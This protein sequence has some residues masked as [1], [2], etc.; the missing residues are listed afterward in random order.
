MIRI[1]SFPIFIFLATLSL[2]SFHAHAQYC[3][4][5]G[6]TYNYEWIKEVKMNSM[7][8]LSG[9]NGYRLFSTPVFQINTGSNQLNL[10]PGFSSNVY[11]EKWSVFI[12]FNQDG[13]FGTGETV[14]NGTSTTALAGTVTVPTTAKSG[15]TRMRVSMAY[16]MAPMPCSNFTYGEVEDY[17]VNI[18]N[19]T[20]PPSTTVITTTLGGFDKTY[21]KDLVIIAKF[22]KGGVLYNSSQ[23]FSTSLGFSRQISL[24]VDKGTQIE[25]SAKVYLATT[26]EEYIPAS[27]SSIVG[28]KCM[29]SAGSV[30]QSVI[31]KLKEHAPPPI[32]PAFDQ[33]I[34]FNNLFGGVSYQPGPSTVIDGV[35]VTTTAN[36]FYNFSGF[37]FT[38]GHL[39][40]INGTFNFPAPVLNLSFQASGQCTNCVQTVNITANG[41]VVGSFTL[42]YNVVSNIVINLP[43]PT[44]SVNFNQSIKMDNLSIDYQ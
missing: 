21:S 29:T 19:T 38:S 36:Y 16:S 44:T 15:S 31:F 20:P 43:F 27:C 18:N 22:S 17:T 41:Q 42:N 37:P 25:W 34:N 9:G 11:S 23:F 40:V 8:S 12:D 5:K 39:G 26:T 13:V 14:F 1:T 33:T 6:T 28:T 10:V 30:G 32:P 24:E 35:T 7:S 2:F 4:S 3:A